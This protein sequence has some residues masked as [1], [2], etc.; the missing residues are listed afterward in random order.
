MLTPEIDYNK[1]MDIAVM[2]VGILLA[3]LY[4]VVA[5]VEFLKGKDKEAF[6]NVVVS[7]IIMT[8]TW[9]LHTILFKGG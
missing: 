1:G 8:I 4:I 3:L 6:E 5:I 7:V 2:T 9:V